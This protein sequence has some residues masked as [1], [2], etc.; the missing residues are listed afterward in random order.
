M[1]A[2][3]AV[4]SKGFVLVVLDSGIDEG[5]AIGIVIWLNVLKQMTQIKYF[6]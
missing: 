1:L 4:L 3:C 5:A 2:I 6:L